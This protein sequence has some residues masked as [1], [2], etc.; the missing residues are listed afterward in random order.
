MER[1]VFHG[2]AIKMIHLIED[3]EVA[4]FIERKPPMGGQL[5]PQRS[6]GK[7]VSDFPQPF[8]YDTL[9]Y[10]LLYSLGALSFT[11]MAKFSNNLIFSGILLSKQRRHFFCG[12]L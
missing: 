2:L 4:D 7:F 12:F 10:P 8:F 5:P 6:S 11:S 3:A 1:P 9:C